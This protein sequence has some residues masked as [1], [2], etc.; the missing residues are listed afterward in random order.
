MTN[1][2]IDSLIARVQS[3]PDRDLV[4]ALAKPGDYT[5][6][7]MVI[8][9]AEAKHRGIQ[10][11]VVRPVAEK[12]AQRKKDQMA[13]SWSIKGIGEKL[14]GKRS[15]GVDGSYQT[16]K[17]F[18]L[19]HLPIHPIASFR[20]QRGEKGGISVVEVLAIDWRQA[21]DT[22]CFVA[23]SW[24]GI[25]AAVRLLE[26]YS[27]PFSEVVGV[28]FL[29]LPAVFLFLLRRRAR[30]GASPIEAGALMKPNQALEPTPTAVTYRAAHA[31]RQP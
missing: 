16:T 19:F 21:V 27:F 15:F 12:E 18:V 30:R 28:A 14:Y 10:A 11:Q 23:L 22:Y 8:Y 13:D 31:P 26:R 25:A 9:E 3:L 4:S 5:P 2:E 6:E 20:V 7:A 29:G 1:S 17:W 24:I